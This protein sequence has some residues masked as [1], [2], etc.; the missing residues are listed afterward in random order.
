MRFFNLV[1]SV[2]TTVALEDEEFP[3]TVAALRHHGGNSCVLTRL[4]AEVLQDFGGVFGVC[5]FH[6][7]F[8]GY[9]AKM[10]T[11]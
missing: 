10:G 7:V 11:S 5:W 4:F 8:I 6:A 9:M 3:L 1:F 2:S